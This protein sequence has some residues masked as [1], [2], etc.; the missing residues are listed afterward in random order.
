LT[1]PSRYDGTRA[2]YTD[3]SKVRGFLD[4]TGRWDPSL[5]FVM[6]GA[7]GVHFVAYRFVPRMPKPVSSRPNWCSVSRL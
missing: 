4:F 6:M 3:T 1:R 2:P 7:I 5:A